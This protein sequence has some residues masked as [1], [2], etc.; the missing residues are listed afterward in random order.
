MLEA[1][2]GGLIASGAIRPQTLVWHEGLENWRAAGEMWPDL[3][4]AGAPSSVGAAVERSLAASVLDPLI[5]RRW[6]FWIVAAAL[7]AGLL[8]SAV[9]IFSVGRSIRG[10]WSLG[11]GLLPMV[12]SVFVRL[13]LIAMATWVALALGRAGKHRQAE[14][15]RGVVSEIGTAAIIAS[16][17]LLVGWLVS[18]PGTLRLLSDL[19]H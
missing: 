16:L 2:L 18:L 8:D 1:E 13:I 11:A 12:V 17:T 10:G 5:Q 7:C 9:S 6:A 19:T 14:A 3:F 15:V 4:R